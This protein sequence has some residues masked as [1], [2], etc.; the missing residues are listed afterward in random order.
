MPALIVWYFIIKDKGLGL[1]AM[2]EKIKAGL[3]E[4]Y[5]QSV[6]KGLEILRQAS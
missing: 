4:R 5:E 3:G 2:S 6:L 1:T